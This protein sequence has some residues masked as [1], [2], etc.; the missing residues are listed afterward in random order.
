M[1]LQKERA[2]LRRPPRITL[3]GGDS[4]TDYTLCPARCNTCG[5]HCRSDVCGACRAW[6]RVYRAHVAMTTALREARYG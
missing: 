4:G 2:A 6:T 1:N 3:G 5:Q